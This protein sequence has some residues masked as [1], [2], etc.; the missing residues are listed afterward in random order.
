MRGRRDLADTQTSVCL[1][2]LQGPYYAYIA[3]VGSAQGTNVG[4]AAAL[5][6]ITSLALCGLLNARYQLEA[7][8]RG[9]S[10]LCT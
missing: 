2:A 1:C 5:A 3:G 9:F 6:G 10:F 4:F 7:R 8:A